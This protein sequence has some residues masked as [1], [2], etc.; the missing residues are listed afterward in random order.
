M[1]V[2]KISKA[3][4]AEFADKLAADTK[5]YAPVAKGDKFDFAPL[6]KAN[7]LRLDY[8]VTLQPPKKYFLPPVETLVTFE[9]GGGYQSSYDNKKFVL[10]GVHPYDMVAINQL[11]T[12]FSSGQYDNHYMTRRVNAT[13]VALDV[14]NAS[15]N[16]FASEMGTATVKD[17]FDIL[18]TDIGDAYVAESATEK[19]Q[20]LLAGAKTTNATENDIKKRQ[21]VQEKNKKELNKH[22]LKCPSSYLPKLLE[23]AYNHEVW[24]EKAAT[25]FACGSC[26]QVC[27]TC[28]CFGV[29]DDVNW[30]MKTGSRCRAW[31][32]CM[33]DGFAKVAGDHDFRK[34]R[35]DRFRHRLYRKAKYVPEK[36]GGQM[37]CVG[38]GR[39]IGACLPDIANPVVI[40]NRLVDDLGI[41]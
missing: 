6:L 17:G 30:D 22:K 19:G 26:N 14:V 11:D 38:C 4:F 29:Q 32:G 18:L 2:K 25:C 27:P 31:D 12:L 39:C 33:L 41:G 9:V 23:K 21:K 20:N 37:A 10:L 5:V 40:Y 1:T 36:I 13:I 24:E 8:D 34:N 15:K 28:Y 7:D 3:D 35:A 16:V